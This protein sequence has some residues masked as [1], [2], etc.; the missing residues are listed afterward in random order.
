MYKTRLKDGEGDEER[1][2]REFCQDLRELSDVTEIRGCSRKRMGQAM[3]GCGIHVLVE[4]EK[5]SKEA[6]RLANIM[7]EAWSEVIEDI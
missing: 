1:A 5:D 6:L 7:V 2:A 3:I 4:S